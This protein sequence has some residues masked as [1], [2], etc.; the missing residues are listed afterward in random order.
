MTDDDVCPIC[1]CPYKRSVTTVMGGSLS[2]DEAKQART[3][4]EPFENVTG[5]PN[6][7]KAE[8][9]AVRLFY[10][11]REQVMEPNDGRDESERIELSN[12]DQ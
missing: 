4:F 2:H 7:A 3:C 5:T 8:V 6:G 11:S 1:E 12:A 10:H 9:S